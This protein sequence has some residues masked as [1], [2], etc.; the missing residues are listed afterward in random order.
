MS[1]SSSGEPLAGGEREHLEMT[2]N[3]MH[4]EHYTKKELYDFKLM[5]RKFDDAANISIEAIDRIEVGKKKL[6]K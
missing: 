1:D 6:L 3:D 4:L 5:M 2:L